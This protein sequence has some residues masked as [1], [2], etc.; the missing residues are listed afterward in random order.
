MNHRTFDSEAAARLRRRRTLAA[1]PLDPA[2]A[3]AAAAAEALA[4]AVTHE[5]AQ[6][7][8]ALS[9]VLREIALL[10]EQGGATAARI[11]A[12]SHEGA[13]RLEEL[14]ALQ[15]ELRAAARMPHGERQRATRLKP[16]FAALEQQLQPSCRA[17]KMQLRV[18]AADAWLRIDAMALRRIVKLLVAN[19]VQHSGASTVAVRA[20]ARPDGLLLAVR[21]DGTG[22]A[23]ERVARLFGDSAE[24]V[25][26]A[27][28]HGFGL[29][30]VRLMLA[31]MSGRLYLRTS[32]A[33]TAV[34]VHWP[35]Q[36]LPAAAVHS[37]PATAGA[38]RGRLIVM[39]DDEPTAL[40]ASA[41]LFEALGAQVMRFTEPLDLLAACPQLPRTPALFILD[42]RLRDG[43]CR[44][45]VDALRLWLKDDFHCVVLTGDDA[46]SH[47]LRDLARDVYVASKP[48]NDWAFAHIQRFLLGE[49]PRLSEGGAAAR[50][51]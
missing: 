31:R 35:R 30:Q 49:I 46:V 39:L 37:A 27:D 23:C 32:S 19:A 45:V 33:G 50:A 13:Q 51:G 8:Q 44:R 3:R 43:T 48:L 20:F 5:A 16:E 6:P 9:A 22:T 21:D 17:M 24:P 28:R 38:L 7:M 25:E 29:D 4:D 47:A 10:A 42:Y 1:L 12:L 34:F 41:R 11:C 2:S 40:A 18:R 14:R 26:R 36:V 15:D